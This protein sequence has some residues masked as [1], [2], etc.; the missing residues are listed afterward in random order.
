MAAYPCSDDPSEIIEAILGAQE[1]ARKFNKFV[2]GGV[3]E[4]VQLG[5]GQPTPTLRNTVHLV[6]SAAATLDGSDVSGKFSDAANGGEAVRMLAE[7][8]GDVVNVKDFGAI[9]DGIE[10][11]TAAFQAASLAVDGDGCIFVPSG[12]YAVSE[13]V[14]GNFLSTGD[15]EII[16][17]K[18][19]YVKNPYF[20]GTKFRKDVILASGPS[21]EAVAY[22]HE[23]W[24]EN[25][26]LSVQGIAIDDDFNLYII[27]DPGNKS[28]NTTDGSIVVEKLNSTGE[29]IGF[30]VFYSELYVEQILIDDYTLKFYG[31]H[32][33]LYIFDISSYA[34]D[35]TPKNPS[36]T[37]TIPISL[38]S[39]FQIFEMGGDLC[40]SIRLPANASVD[41]SA[42]REIILKFSSDMS[43]LTGYTAFDYADCGW[44]GVGTQ[45]DGT[46]ARM[47][48]PKRQSICAD[49]TGFAVCVGGACKPSDSGVDT[50]YG[51]Y[52]QGVMTFN[53]KA[54]RKDTVVCHPDK[55]ISKIAS[56][57]ITCDRIEAEG[58]FYKNGQYFS[59]FSRAN[60]G[61]YIVFREMSESAS[62]IDFIDCKSPVC[63]IN[64]LN[65]LNNLP[66]IAG[67]VYNPD[68]G[69]QFSDI[70]DIILWMRD[71][72]RQ[73]IRFTAY[74]GNT[75]LTFTGLP[76]TPTVSI[77]IKNRYSTG[78]YIVCSEPFNFGDYTL[79][80]TLD[81]D[82]IDKVY[83]EQLTTPS[84]RL[85]GLN[86]AGDNFRII[87]ENNDFSVAGLLF[88]H[89]S[90]EFDQI[91]YG[92]NST[93]HAAVLG[94][95]FMLASSYGQRQGSAA[96]RITGAGLYP[97]PTDT[98]SCG[99][100]TARWSNVYAATGTVQTSDRRKKDN[101]ED[102]D[103]ALMRA[104]RNVRFKVFQ[105]KS[106]IESKGVEEARLHVGIIAQDLQ[107]AFSAEGLD[108]SRYGFFC[109]DEWE[110]QYEYVEVADRD[111]NDQ[112]VRTHMERQLIAPAGSCYAIRYEEALALECAYQR[113]LGEKRDARIAELEAK[114]NELSGNSPAPSGASPDNI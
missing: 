20:S 104:W 34:W 21:E 98:R 7:R 97:D 14:D 81:G 95:K 107:E 62:S 45:G 6:K 85:K 89:T 56:L 78:F 15:V 8:F 61:R 105:F 100:G 80:V 24:G 96:I 42:S 76:I 86:P 39:D 69:E 49:E 82:N 50:S 16:G 101:I 83:T 33:Q 113:W 19:V 75:Q 74:A 12:S 71:T 72:K 60:Q 110:D 106:S 58:I 65:T 109:Y 79:Y 99:T 41:N 103:N 53:S 13:H 37:K 114:L 36:S 67:Y 18:T 52:H 23:R 31:S 38:Q 68:T 3:T 94:H 59:I 4:E 44:S 1:N 93:L 112:V 108:A 102:V 29:S 48:Y 9:G 51:W 64:E 63:G 30:G 73:E 35:G 28:T 11:D 5:A 2:N 88:E 57:G 32:T 92:G 55:I 40:N 84:I 26:Y 47:A 70:L 27:Y 25:A 22:T 54:E 43:S 66:L 17:A 91:A 111:E 77:T 46:D 90:G 87:S 10:D